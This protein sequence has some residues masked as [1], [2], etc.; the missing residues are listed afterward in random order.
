MISDTISITCVDECMLVSSCYLFDN[1]ILNPNT[2]ACIGWM[3]VS[4][5]DAMMH[6]LTNAI[7]VIEI[8]RAERT[9]GEDKV[10]GVTFFG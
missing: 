10:I 8:T 2:V 5:I 9:W 3:N 6:I 4:G 1:N 7:G